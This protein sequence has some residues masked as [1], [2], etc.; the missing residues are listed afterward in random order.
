[1]VPLSAIR[2]EID[3]SRNIYSYADI[4]AAEEKLDKEGVGDSG[5]VDWSP[6]GL[7]K[8]RVGE[9]FVVDEVMEKKE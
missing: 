3:T 8:R 5:R 7:A 1:M 2:D 9:Y 6:V 4:L